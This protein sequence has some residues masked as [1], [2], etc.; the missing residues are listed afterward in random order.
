MGQFGVA[1]TPQDG[2]GILGL[3]R[4]KA[5]RYKT[6]LAHYRGRGGLEASQI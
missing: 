2:I 6:K 3:C 5:Q 1:P 4:V